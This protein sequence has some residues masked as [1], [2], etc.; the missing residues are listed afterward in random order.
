MSV[1]IDI[2]KCTLCGK[3]VTVCP[4]RVIFIEGKTISANAEDCML[5]S[6]CYDVCRKN[7]ISFSESD[8]KQINFS[9][10]KTPG[11]SEKI[12]K[13]GLA[14]FFRSRR[15]V[16]SYFDREPSEELIR[17][18]IEFAVTAPSGSNCQNW[19]FTA[20][21]GREKV[22]GLALDIKKFFIKLNS[23]AENPIIRYLSI[24]F[25]KGALKKYYDEHIGSVRL[26]LEESDK[27]I[28]LLFHGAPCVIIIHDNGE[29]STPLED[30]QYAGYNIALLAHA[31][32]MGTCFIGYAVE[33][34]NRMGRVKEKYGIPVKNRV[35]CVL[36]LGFPAGKF[37]RASLRKPYTVRIV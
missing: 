1:T 15:S 24:P 12:S 16:R 6:H 17:D 13:E 20:V 14:D 27:G 19:E 3:C 26:A 35:R 25:T 10:I 18:L 22:W 9:T 36:T 30:A 2:E 32:G 4:K 37:L 5:C 29:G 21:A 31:M 8:L 11:K 23:M 7:A 34:L 33:S 28:D